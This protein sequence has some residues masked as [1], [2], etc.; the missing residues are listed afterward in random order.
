MVH[1]GEF[2][3]SWSLRSNSVTRQVNF[4]TTKIG[5][6]CQNSNAT[7]WVI[8]K[9]CVPVSTACIGFGTSWERISSFGTAGISSIS[10]LSLSFRLTPFFL[11]FLLPFGLPWGPF[12]FFGLIGFSSLFLALTKAFLSASVGMSQ[13]SFQNSW[14]KLSFSSL[15]SSKSGFSGSHSGCLIL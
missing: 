5:E 10:R 3:K 9:Q 8:F 11:A 7:C 4:N 1:F 6:K 13:D 2:L 15:R 14:L 12:R